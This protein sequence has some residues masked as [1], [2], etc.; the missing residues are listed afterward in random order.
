MI[1]SLAASYN[2]CI[3]GFIV[4][5]MSS[6]GLSLDPDFTVKGVRGMLGEMRERPHIFKGRRILY[7]HTGKER[8][9]GTVTIAS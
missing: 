9:G 5:V 2:E 7:I 8:E 4:K 6:T 3:A 1:A